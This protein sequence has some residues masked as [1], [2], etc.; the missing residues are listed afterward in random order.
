MSRRAKS[1]SR[2]AGEMREGRVVDGGQRRRTEGWSWDVG[3][4]KKA[5]KKQLLDLAF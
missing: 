5:H 1:G 2:K 4:G 3:G